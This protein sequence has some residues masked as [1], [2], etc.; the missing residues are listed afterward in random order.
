MRTI[1]RNINYL[2]LTKSIRDVSM[3]RTLGLQIFPS[4]PLYFLSA[5]QQAIEMN[6]YGW[7][8]VDFRPDTPSPFRL[9]SGLFKGW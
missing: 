8:L 3:I 6:E 9:R 5:Y 4:T 2:I 7:L 1:N